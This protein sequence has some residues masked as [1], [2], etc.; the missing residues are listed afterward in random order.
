MV[1]LSGPTER[2]VLDTFALMTQDYPRFAGAGFERAVTKLAAR[3]PVGA[4]P[5]VMSQ[6]AVLLSEMQAAGHLPRIRSGR[7]RAAGRDEV[8]LFALLGAAQHGNKARAIEAAIALLDTG[9]VHG[10]VAAAI[11]LGARLAE[12]GVW[13]RS[14]GAAAFDYMAGYPAVAG[15][16]GP[17]SVPVPASS[18]EAKRPTLHV[19]QSA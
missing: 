5:M 8:F 16:I 10:V 4:T 1:L 18:A 15:P 9:H 2:L 6:F 19:L 13:L 14:L 11:A 17:T 7:I 3:L 12:S